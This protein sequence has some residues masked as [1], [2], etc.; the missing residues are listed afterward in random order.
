MDS[1][2]QLVIY[3]E[4]D[5]ENRVY[6]DVCDKL[7]IQQFYKNHLISQTHTNKIHKRQQLKESS[8]KFSLKK[9]MNILCKACDKDIIENESKNYHYM[10][11]LTEEYDK[12]FYENY[13]INNP[14]LDEIEKLLNEYISSYNNELHAHL[15]N[16]EFYLEFDNNLKIHIE[17]F[18]CLND[19]DITKVKGYLFHWIDYYKLQ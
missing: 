7:C 19:D 13:S 8:Q 9:I 3:C 2:N 5:R 11:T 10:A 15:I 14:N 18:F 1:D 17:S 4:G 12:S 6:C 16:C